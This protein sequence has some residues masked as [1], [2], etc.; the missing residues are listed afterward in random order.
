MASGMSGNMKIGIV[1]YPTFGGSGVVATEL[2]L[3]L[4]A[5]GHDVHFVSYDPPARYRCPSERVTFHEVE[6]P[7]YPLF[8]YPP[9]LLSMASTMADVAENEKLDLFHVHYAIPHTISASIARE[10]LGRSR[11]PIVTTLHGTDITI[12]GRRREYFRVVKFALEASSGVTAVSRSLAEETRET[13]GFDGDIEVIPNFVEPDRYR[14]GSSAEV[15]AR[16]ASPEEKLLVHVSNFRPVKNV[17]DVVKV[18]AR[19]SAELPA[20]LVLVGDGPEAAACRELARELGIEERVRFLGE[21]PDV[22]PLLAC[23]VPEVVA[24]EETGELFRPG[25]VDAM[26]R[27]AVAILSDGPRVDAM[28]AA[29]RSRAVER[30][31]AEKVVPMYEAFYE[32]VLGRARQV[33]R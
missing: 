30:F 13:F 5:R 1:C 27:A 32:R 29:A 18:F 6:T 24:D 3:E 21:T 4:A 7:S 31:S 16:F 33:G 15:R 12:V 23:G 10:I 14:P 17:P 26:S 25:D 22:A 9:Y 2:G 19:V 11:M 28:R 20:R 8:R